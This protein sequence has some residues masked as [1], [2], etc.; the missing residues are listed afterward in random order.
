MPLRIAVIRTESSGHAR[1]TPSMFERV[2]VLENR[3]V[4]DFSAAVS[5]AIHSQMQIRRCDGR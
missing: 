3:E 5:D 4:L 2:K 1:M